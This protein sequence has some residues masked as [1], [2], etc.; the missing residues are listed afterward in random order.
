MHPVRDLTNF[1][2]NATK[3]GAPEVF[4]AVRRFGIPACPVWRSGAVRHR[5]AVAAGEPLGRPWR[6]SDR[7]TAGRA[8]RAHALPRA[9]ARDRDPQRA[10]GLTAGGG[11][12]PGLSRAV[13]LGPARILGHPVHAAG[14]DHRADDPDRPDHRGADAADYRGPVGRIPR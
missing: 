7:T 4:D 6:R 8:D 9:S 14:H 5:T 10:D 1:A 11:G 12:A 13:A 3:F 2:L